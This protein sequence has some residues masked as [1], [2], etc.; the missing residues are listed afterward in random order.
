[1]VIIS[2]THGCLCVIHAYGK[3]K[4][5]Y[6]ETIYLFIYFYLRSGGRGKTGRLILGLLCLALLL[7]L[8]RS[9]GVV[10]I[11][12]PLLPVRNLISSL[13]LQWML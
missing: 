8:W 4:I 13:G 9:G 10:V 2:L 12:P 6:L 7:L 5:I 11:T 3:V 1:M